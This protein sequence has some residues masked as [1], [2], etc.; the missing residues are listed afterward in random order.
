MKIRLYG[1][2]KVLSGLAIKLLG[3]ALCVWGFAAFAI[4]LPYRFVFYGPLFL[5][6]SGIVLI[7][8]DRLD[9]ARRR[10]KTA[11]KEHVIE[12]QSG[13]DMRKGSRL[14]LYLSYLFLTSSVI[15]SY[16]G[17]R[18]LD[19]ELGMAVLLLAIMFVGAGF[20]L[21]FY[22]SLLFGLN[23]YR[24]RLLDTSDHLKD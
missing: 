13:S 12:R 21:M 8:F 6:F 11:R 19:P 10:L 16:F 2:V 1:T 7:N 15:I 17:G 3:F 20:G 5:L 22:R 9:E 24:N 18:M 4:N 14:T 23:T